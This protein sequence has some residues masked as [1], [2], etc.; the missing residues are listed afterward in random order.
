MGT[1]VLLSV[2]NGKAS[3]GTTLALKGLSSGQHQATAEVTNGVG[4]KTTYTWT[5]S[6]DVDTTAPIISNPQPSPQSIIGDLGGKDVVIS[7]N[8]T[9][10]QSKVSKVAVKLDGSAKSAKISD[11]LAFVKV[12]GLKL[13]SSL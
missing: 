8:V 9:D 4:L 1:K 5:F 11:G 3:Q 7:V 2:D 6:V 10:E 12:S 13:T